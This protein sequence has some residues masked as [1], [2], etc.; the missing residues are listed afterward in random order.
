MNTRTIYIIAAAVVIVL[1]VTLIGWALFIGTQQQQLREGTQDVGYT[2]TGA[3]GSGGSGFFGGFFGTDT[4]TD[5]DTSAATTTSPRDR[6]QLQQVYNLPVAG[7]A[8][9]PT[10]VLFVDRATGH[11]FSRP[12]RGGETERIAQ[13]TIPQVYD[14]VFVDDTDSVLLRYL[15]ERERLISVIKPVGSTD[16]TTSLPPNTRS[17]ARSP[18]TQ[19]LAYVQPTSRGANLVI[20]DADGSNAEVA[21][22]STLRSWHV[23]WVNDETIVLTQHA[24]AGVTGTAV[25]IS[26]ADSS[27]TPVISRLSAL[28]TRMSPS[29]D[30]L[31]YSTSAEDGAAPRLFVQGASGERTELP[32]RTFASL[33]AWNPTD[34][35]HAICA[36]PTTF[37]QAR[38]PDDWY[39]G[40]VQLATS[41]WQLMVTDEGVEAIE[42]F[43]PQSSVNTTLAAEEL[44]FNATGD[45]VFFTN[46]TDQTLWS[47][48]LPTPDNENETS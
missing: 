16:I 11:I 42:L 37:P 2:G 7:A 4:D 47:L 28:E 45:V 19:R 17:V 43:S 6:I 24:A 22:E 29:G 33:C 34:A 18:D 40:R 13:T 30:V 46:R 25:H 27:A 3:G 41:F 9:T 36:V 39:K 44:F 10:D 14:A 35:A 5:L 31:L 15:D 12:Q 26:L 8:T 21:W 48:L 20:V 23:A 38:Y 1:I 32:M